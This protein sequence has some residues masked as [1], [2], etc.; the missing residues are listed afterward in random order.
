VA[1]PALP[2]I[3]IKGELSMNDDSGGRASE[4]FD[5]IVVGSGAGGGP[6]A[7][8]LA[9]NGFRVLVIEAGSGET[10]VTP[11][12]ESP[13]ISLVPALHAVSTEDPQLSWRFFVKH[14]DVPPTGNDWKRYPPA[15]ATDEAKA[16]GD[17]FYPRAAALGG[18]TIHNA[19]IT[20]AGPDSD[21]D[22]LADYLG[23]DSWRSDRM[24][25]YFQRMERNEYLDK[26]TPIPRTVW[27]RLWDNIKWLFG[28]DADHTGGRHGYAGWLHTSVTD[29]ELG[30]SDKKL[31]KMIKA[32]LWQASRAGLE[33]A[34]TL[35]KDIFRGNIKRLLDP[36]HSVTQAEHPEGVVLIP[37]AV[38]GAATTIHQNRATQ[39]VRRGRRSS[40][41]ELL[42]EVRASHPDQLV[43]WTDCLVTRVLFD[44]G[45]TPRAVG[46]ELLRG[47]RLYKAHVVPSMEPGKEDRV[48][49]KPG[50]EVILCGGS[51]NTP[52]LLMLSGIGE[53][54]HLESVAGEADLCCFRDRNSQ[55]IRDG[56]GRPRRL[57]RPGVGLN[58]QDRY[59]VSLIS[60][61]N[62][63][64]TL[65]EGA[66]FRLPA[67]TAEPDRH[68]REWREQGTG[69]YA[70]NGGVLA[71]LKR[72]RPDLNQPDL[73]IFGVPLPFPGYHVGYSD[74]GKYH[75]YFT[76][77]IL[78]GHT[79]NNG[80]TVRLKSTSPQD[81]PIINFHYFNEHTK[82]GQ[83]MD[84]P[85]L[86]ALVD[87]VKFVRGITQKAWFAPWRE[88]Y[89]GDSKAATRTEGDA[90]AN[91][92][93]PW[94]DTHPTDRVDP[95]PTEDEESIKKWI[96]RE[97]WGH[98]ACGTCRLG[99]DGD[100]YAVL[101]SRFRVRGVTGLRVVDASIF[102]NIP[103]YFIVTNIY[104]ASEKAADVVIE[105]ARD[106]HDTM[107]EYPR[108]LRDREAEALT[109]R[110]EEIRR[111]PIDADA[112]LPPP[113]VD[114]VTWADGVTGLGLSGG[115]IRSAT[116][117]LGVLQ[118]LA[119]GRCLRRV[120]FLSTVSG[121]GYIGSFLGRFY[122][123][124][125]VDPLLGA[126]SR[127]ARPSPSRVEQGLTDPHSPEVDWLRQQSNYLAPM[128]SGD[129]RLDL[130][131]FLR[132]FLTVHFVVGVLLFALFGLANAIRYGLFD[133][134]TAGLGL[135][136]I[137]AGDMPIGHLVREF[138]GPFFSP[139]FVL[140]EL[141]VLFLA[142]PRAVGYW[143][144][145]Q[146]DHGR[147][148]GPALTLLFIVA[149]VLV[150]LGVW[151]GFAYEP[152]LLGLALF[153]TFIQVELAWH[154][155]DLRKDAVGTGGV[156]TQRLLTRNYLTYDLGLALALAGAALGFAAIDTIAHGLQQYV[157]RNRTYVVAFSSFLVA[158]A[159]LIP[160][161]R[162]LAGWAAAERK[163][164]PASAT[165]R[166]IREQVIGGLLAVILFTVPLILYA[167]A[168]HAA[169]QGGSTLVAG[170]A[171]TLL[172][173]LISL[174]LTH[175]KAL[176]VVNRSS[177][178]Q[179]YAARLART[180]LGASNPARRHPEGANVTEVIPGDDVASIVDYR[181]HEGGGPLHLI[182]T[183]VNQTI[184][185]SS[186]RGNRSRQ[187]EN[188]AVSSL[189]MSIGKIWHAAWAGSSAAG[190]LQPRTSGVVPLGH[191]PGEE[192]P[193]IDET[194]AP[195]L[196]AEVLPL[197]Q[198]I[199]ISGAA[200][201]PGRGQGTR[202]GTALLFGLANL[203]TGY[204]WDSGITAS[205]RSGFPR[206]SFLRRL[207]SLIPRAF[208][209]QA[210]LISEWVA[211]YPGPWDRY[212]NISDGGFFDNL[213]GYELIRRRV[214]RI[215][216]ADATADPAYHYDDFGELVRKVRIDFN[217]SIEPITAADLNQLAI[218]G[219]I[220][221]AQRARLGTLD[222]LKPPMD[223]DGNIIGP[224]RKHAA[225][226]RVR[227]LTGPQRT[228]LLLYLKASRTGDEAADV[229]EYRALHPDFP[230]EGTINQFFD[231]AQ[232]ESYRRLGEHVASPLFAD[233]G[234]FW[235]IP[236]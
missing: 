46:V 228:S 170:L 99:P 106:A 20:I 129:A 122:D 162:A 135:L 150:V 88:K 103:G 155:G 78:K 178:S 232:W 73:F 76:W 3:E 19:L 147:F 81:T 28:F 115:G 166:A 79:R 50:G 108:A 112:A 37:T 127:P 17:I 57:H 163:P 53:V 27:G 187:G 93:A 158:I 164:G 34:D 44:D 211:L 48:Y 174:I 144:V 210:M 182:N 107:P 7:A 92:W 203:R 45:E 168:S 215:I 137:D 52:Q 216:L 165:V 64:L 234:W 85:D 227:Y 1:V 30:L 13:E 69:L 89:P 51:F 188:L 63:D 91:E 159:G 104:V 59:E 191:R 12:A 199:A 18:C 6:L 65:L 119:N 101:D 55:V 8:R 98:H 87:G 9:Q 10:A 41:R 219:L 186:M 169:Y 152:L 149:T 71:I 62:Q 124:L 31:V 58:L 176:A 184:D 146:N 190:P 160:I 172:A 151:D 205:A 133:P 202:L 153:S 130:A 102:P 206:L 120:D 2:H 193:L 148:Q 49:V 220:T 96:L 33:R 198:W 167:F 209:P 207:L 195:T 26:P 233:P 109:C 118:G 200:V 161:L 235:A 180:Y 201:G 84:D 125:R 175:P 181:P 83:Y 110:R 67:D 117:N 132:N 229:E 43:I 143:V 56:N 156:E 173:C 138:L 218:D 217:A 38:C 61:F 105:D 224:S 230:H 97:A 225:L 183:T 72:S 70:T 42:L 194:G 171:A 29:L 214:P 136:L 134:A 94:R 185:F 80:G 221:A 111:D 157:A 77:A 74:V 86:I 35:V 95:F 121:G 128:G 196:W 54:G 192:H 177:L 189:A 140:F 222:D 100:E 114:D 213:G 47:A 25:A 60:E 142:L 223:R 116:F 23:D 145:S 126:G 231:E 141:I 131:G 236:L 68:L 139:W 113:L 24:R 208:P 4:E 36:N 90:N 197:R 16:G 204:W 40:P 5:Y 75:K 22:D 123:R 179:E 39:N 32:A 66:T 14:Y 82:P 21:W 212:W 15:S 226:F 154:H 11:P